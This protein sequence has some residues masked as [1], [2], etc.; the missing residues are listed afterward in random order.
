MTNRSGAY[1]WPDD[2]AADVYVVDADGVF[3][4]SPQVREIMDSGHRRYE[5]RMPGDHFAILVRRK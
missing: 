1:G 5:V 3:V 4:P 2:S